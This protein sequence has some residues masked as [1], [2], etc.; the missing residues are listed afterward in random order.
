MNNPLFKSGMRLMQRIPTPVGMAGE[1]QGDH[2]AVDV[3]VYLAGHGGEGM[4]DFL[5]NLLS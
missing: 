1:G 5:H 4:F 3:R 2:T